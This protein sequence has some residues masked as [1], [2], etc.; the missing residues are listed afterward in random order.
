MAGGQGTRFWPLS[1][2]DSPKQ[3]L[4]FLGEKS[5]FQL[6]VARLKEIVAP[7]DI[8]VICSGQYV[9]LVL[10]QAPELKEEQ[11]IVEPAPR[12]T[13]A[14]IGL[15]AMYLQS[16][17]P[18]EIMGVFPSDHLIQDTGRFREVVEFA[19]TLA[20]RGDLVTFG[21]QPEF[22]ATGYGYLEKG[23]FVESIKNN[24]AFRVARFT[25]KPDQP[26]AEK[27]VDSGRYFWNSGMFIWAVS[28]ILEEISLHM[29]D[30]MRILENLEYRGAWSARETSVFKTAGP[31]SIDYGVME[32]C[33][34]VVMVPCDLKWSDV[35]DWN[36]VAELLESG[37]ENRSNDDSALL[38][39]SR[40][41]FVHSEGKKRIAILGV[42]D[43]ILVE[44]GDS[45]LVCSRDRSQDVGKIVQLLK[46]EN[47]ELT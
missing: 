7:A 12:N 36:A 10:S 13:A 24:D 9:D 27:F 34:R 1:R 44:T 19:G 23:A 20:A 30:L 11:V 32:K 42:N 31:V 5:L 17:Y 14:C 28:A 21:I 15:A 35:G 22:P 26:T 45:I 46:K 18:G 47:P 39:D 40:N 6:T 2:K 37:V 25:E 38:I 41:C 33:S 3:F 8:F 16:R 43:L 29:P 4:N